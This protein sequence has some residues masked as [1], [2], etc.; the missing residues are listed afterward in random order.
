MT[1]YRETEL[2]EHRYLHD[3]VYHANRELV[4]GLVEAEVLMTVT[5]DTKRMAMFLFKR[6]G[7]VGIP[8]PELFT[9]VQDAFDAAVKEETS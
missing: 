3:A 9:D 7:Y 4:R 1:Y 6:Q 2:D 5:I 8:N